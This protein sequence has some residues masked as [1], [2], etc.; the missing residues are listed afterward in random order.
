MA[1]GRQHTVLLRSDGMAVACG[2]YGPCEIPP[3]EG[4]LKYTQVA[5]GFDHTVLLRSDGMAVALPYNARH[6]VP[7]LVADQ[8][9]IFECTFLVWSVL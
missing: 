7:A 5:A 3:L 6:A 2:D 8:V 9:Y 4:N 1:A